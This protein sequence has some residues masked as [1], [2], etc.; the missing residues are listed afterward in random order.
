MACRIGLS[1]MNII[2]DENLL[3]SAH[4]VGGILKA[5]FIALKQSCSCIGQISGRGLYLGVDVI[6]PGSD[7]VPNP[8]L[9]Q[10]VAQRYV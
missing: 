7:R 6:V 10:R 5:G 4:S 9:A 8:V 1:V 3:A 2:S